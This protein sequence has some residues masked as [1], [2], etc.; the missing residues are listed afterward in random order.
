[1]I[2]S[3]DVNTLVRRSTQI[4]EFAEE[5]ISASVLNKLLR[6]DVIK[7]VEPGGKPIIESGKTVD[8]M[9]MILTVSGLLDFNLSLKHGD[10]H[11]CIIVNISVRTS[12][13]P[14]KVKST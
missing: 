2:I 9:A 7:E 1:M 4:P 12:L 6:Q 13:T 5:N 3:L 10:V 8:F 14:F 11:T